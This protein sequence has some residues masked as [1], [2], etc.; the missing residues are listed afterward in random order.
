MEYPTDDD[1]VL[2]SKFASWIECCDDYW[3][4][5]DRIEPDGETIHS[6]DPECLPF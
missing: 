4:D 3:D 5:L 2:A 1:V 6:F